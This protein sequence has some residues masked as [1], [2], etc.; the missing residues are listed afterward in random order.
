VNNNSSNSSSS[1]SSS[2]SCSSSSSS[3]SSN[4]SKCRKF[5]YNCHM[6][7]RQHNKKITWVLDLDEYLLEDHSLHSQIQLFT[8]T[9]YSN[10]SSS[11]L[12]ILA[13]LVSVLSALL[14]AQLSLDLVGHELSWFLVGYELPGL[15]SDTNLLLL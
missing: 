4:S 7:P 13:P 3:S 12:Y 1:S 14:G 9:T 8:L 10:V 6:F 5:Y 11:V 2:C 15:L